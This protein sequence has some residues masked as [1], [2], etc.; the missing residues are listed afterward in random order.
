MPESPWPKLRTTPTL[1]PVAPDAALPYVELDVSSN[2]SFLRGASH[3][4]ELVT[5]AAE[6][7]YRAI[8]LTDLHSLAGVVRAHEAAKQLNLKL[9]IGARLQFED[10]PELLVWAPHRDAY[11]RLCRLLTLGKRRAEKGQCQL[12]LADFLDHQQGLLAAVVLGPRR[13]LDAPAM[14]ALKDALGPRL[15][16]AA[17]CLYGRDDQTGL[18]RLIEQSRR[19]NIPLVATNPAHYHDPSRRML[20]DVLCCIRHGCTIAQAG[21][22]LF[23]N[24]ERYL[25]S[26]WQ[27]HRLFA[28]HP[29]AIA[30]ALQIAQQCTFSLD[31]LRYEYPDEIV[32]QGR[33]ALDHLQQLTWQGARQRY[34]AGIPDKVRKLIEHEL[35]LIGQL[36]FEAYFLT[37]H[38]LVEFARGRGILCQGRGSAANSA[39]C[40]CLGV[41]SVDPA[42]IDLLFERFISAARGEPPDIDI[43]FEHERREEVLQYIYQKYGRDRAGMT[44]EVITYRGRSA[45]RDV[46]KALGLSLD[47]VD[48]MARKLDWWERG[49][50]DPQRLRECGL[51]PADR[52]VRQVV[53]LTAQ[54]LGFPRHL[55]QHVGGMVMTRGPLCE[56][57][58]IENAAMPQRTVIEWDKDDIDTLGILKVDCLGLGM[59]SCISKALGMIRE[60]AMEGKEGIEA[61][62]RRSDGATEGEERI[63]QWSNQEVNSILEAQPHGEGTD[64][65]RFDCVAK[66]QGVGQGRLYRDPTNAQRGAVWTHHPDASGSGVHCIQ[67]CG[68]PCS[69]ESSRLPEVFADRPR[70]SGGID[71]ADSDCIGVGTDADQSGGGVIDSRDRSCAARTHQGSGEQTISG[72]SSPSRNRS[73]AASHCFP[74]SLRRSVASSLH[75][76]TIPPEDPAVYDMICHADTIGVFQIESRAQMSMLPRLRPRCFYD[77]VIEVAIMRPGPIQGDMVHPYLRRRSGQEPVHYPSEAIRGVLQKTLGVP[78]FQEQAMRL[79]IVGAGFDAAEADR[80]RRA[81]AAWKRRGGLEQFRDKFINGMLANGYSMAFAQQCFHQLHGFSEYGFPESHAAS[82]ALLVY[83]S[84]WLKRHH[85][86]AFAAALLNSQPMGFYAPAQIIGDARNHGVEVRPMDINAS[87]WDCTLEDS[88]PRQAPVAQSSRPRDS[89]WGMGG[90]ALRIGLRQIKGFR[91]VHAERI[92]RHRQEH[93]PIKSIEQL[94]QRCGLPSTAIGL[95]ARAD[96]LG[97]LGLSRRTAMWESLALEDEPSPLFDAVPVTEPS[98]GILLPVM[99]VGQEVMTDYRTAGHSLKHHPLEL[100]RQ[101]L[102]TRDIL[103]ARQIQ[104][105]PNSHWV[106]SAGLVLVRQRPA[107]AAGMVFMTLE[108]ETGVINLMVRPTIYQRYRAAARHAGLLQVEGRIQRQ[109]EVVNVVAQRLVDLSGLLEGWSGRSRDFH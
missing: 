48:Q 34:P 1:T 43:D 57:V 47:M 55:S 103:P 19:W 54:L 45:V 20:Q 62:E 31:E 42:R 71:D 96:A 87:H 80:L 83:V 22:R 82:F 24:A 12:T 108:D 98:A 33:S 41:T 60:E 78:L 93:G 29:S 85:P 3:P 23:A 10:A 76:H 105:A 26:P 66:G 59:L 30:R 89:L 79:A 27:M 2:F 90:P 75:L 8:A 35:A 84:A 99:P 32:P 107:T 5:R 81:M 21:R 38:D 50:I 15:S 25:K 94:Q 104:Q 36:R 6:L 92:V 53:Q 97:S 49:T 18:Q 39:V 16:L 100:L 28:Q 86:A 40:Y 11:G 72:C 52:A 102:R 95:L 46:G 63:E 58:P 51:D 61:T 77:L 7:G 73:F 13:R 17:S 64:I 69:P 56:L 44:A 14:S 101:E 37:V 68:R 106:K 91:Q 70:L 4:D 67:H 74:S 88:A 109:G 9:I 65:S